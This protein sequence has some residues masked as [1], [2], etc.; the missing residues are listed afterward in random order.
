MHGPNAITRRTFAA[1]LLLGGTLARFGF[2]ETRPVAT[3]RLLYVATPG[4]RDYLEYG[5]HGVLVYD[6]DNGHKF[7]RRITSAG[8][9]DKGKPRNV[10]GICASA[11]TGRLYVSTTHTLTCYDLTTDK[12]LWERAYE[13]GCDRG[14]IAPDGSHLYVPSFEGA[15]WNVV[16][17]KE[18]AVIG[19]IIPNSGAHNT[20][21]GP[22]GKGIY[23]AGLRS[24]LLTVADPKTHTASG[25]IG[26]F[27]GAVRPFTVDGTE[28]LVYACVNGLLGFEI[29]DL[30]TGKVIKRVEVPGFKTGPVKRHGCP[31][32]GIG[33]TP[34]GREIWVCDSF[35]QRMHLFDAALPDVKYL[36]SLTMRDEPGWITFSIDGTRAYPSTGEVIDVKSRKTLT[37]LSDE[38]GRQVQSEKLLEIDFDG[39]TPVNAGDQFGRGRPPVV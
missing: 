14:P 19:T 11:K 22:L 16:D 12:I 34:D 21:Y 20:V 17:G 37:T 27:S 13:G 24:P 33:L 23:L 39:P 2:A 32:H 15:N 36:E 9:D 35:N 30:K 8:K 10:K 26:P 5:G 18:G 29:G 4:I 7:L 28:S 25:K 38:T 1:S 31:S 6:I 3:K